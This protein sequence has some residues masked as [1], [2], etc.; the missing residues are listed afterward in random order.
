MQRLELQENQHD[1]TPI[2]EG[3]I[4]S[5][6]NTS[7]KESGG[8][9]WVTA[10][11][12][13]GGNIQEQKFSILSFCVDWNV[14]LNLEVFD[15]PLNDNTTLLTVKTFDDENTAQAFANDLDK[16]QPIEGVKLTVMPISPDNFNTM[17]EQKSF[18]PYLAFYRKKGNSHKE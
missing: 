8:K 5:S 7:F 6:S 13:T 9:F 14:N 15:S 18:S 12:P 1:E 4:D 17:V 2:V 16:A 10:A 11:I 3:E